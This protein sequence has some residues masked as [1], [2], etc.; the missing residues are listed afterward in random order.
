M[1]LRMVDDKV[2]YDCFLCKR[3]FQ[4]GDHVYKG[5]HI[6]AWDVEICDGCLSSNWDGIVP[7]THP[8]L[9]EHLKAKEIPVTL[10]PRGW[11]DI[12]LR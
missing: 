1:S 9:I 4:F 3:P 5:R 10:N 8:D 12:P 11:I 7:D 2:C 6:A